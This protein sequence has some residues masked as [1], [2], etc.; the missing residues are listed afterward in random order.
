[1]VDITS[2]L[3]VLVLLVA[4]SSPFVY[5]TRKKKQHE[6]K[7]V[8]NFM[9]IAKEHHLNIGPF[10]LWGRAYVIGLDMHQH[11]ILHVKFA[12]ELQVNLVDLKKIQEIQIT[13]E[14][15]FVGEDKQKITERLA[16]FLRH[17]DPKVPAMSLE[18]YNDK[19]SIGLLGEP[20]II[21]K[22]YGKI[23]E[24]LADL[25]KTGISEKVPI[26]ESFDS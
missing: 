18:F 23:K 21:K 1:M 11:F 15:R 2:F 24:E 26:K 22:W 9:A 12:P 8:K 16:L 25:K 6:K 13:D 17:M 20:L 4:F 5:Y 7:L 3:I 10:E 19:E 14:H